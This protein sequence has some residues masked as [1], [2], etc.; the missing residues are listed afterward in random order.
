MTGRVQYLTGACPAC[1]GKC[2]AT[3]E[4][5]VPVQSCTRCGGV[6][7]LPSRPLY[8]GEAYDLVLPFMAKEDVAVEQLRYFD[9]TY[10][11][12]LMGGVGRRHGWYD[13]RTRL[14]HQS[15]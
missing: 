11:D 10:L 4:R 2:K 8:K 13:P 15:G 9:F 3:T 12:G 7:N 1:G 5:G 14:V 6:S